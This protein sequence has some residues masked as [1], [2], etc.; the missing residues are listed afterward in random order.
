[1]DGDLRLANGRVDYLHDELRDL[2]AAMDARFDRVDQRLDNLDRRLRALESWQARVMG[3][4]A[5]VAAVVSAG[6]QWLTGRRA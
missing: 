5:A 3:I 4:A 2:R 6:W 1:M